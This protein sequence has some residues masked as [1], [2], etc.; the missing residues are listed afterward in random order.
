MNRRKVLAVKHVRLAALLFVALTVAALV[1]I[2]A[3]H[4]HKFGHLVG[5]GVHMD[6]CLGNSDIGRKDMFYARVWNLS[7]HALYVEG[8]RVRSE[9]RAEFAYH[10]DVQRWNKRTSTWDSLKGADNWVPTPFGQEL[11][12]GCKPE[13]THINPF[14]TRVLGWVFKDWVTTGEPVRIA[15]HTSL[16]S[17]PSQQRILYTESF[18]VRQF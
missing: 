15:V 12:E 7:P 10:W 6:V 1:C 9:D 3:I 16:H 18:V 13:M 5:H 11:S 17:P 8:C 2:E 4:Y 14:S